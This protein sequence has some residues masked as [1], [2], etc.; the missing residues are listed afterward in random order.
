M[1][2]TNRNTSHKQKYKP[3]FGPDPVHPTAY[4]AAEFDKH[5]WKNFF[6]FC[7]VRNPYE[8]IVSDFMFS[9][10]QKKATVSFREFLERLADSSRP[11][12]E[13]VIPQNPYNWSMYAINDSISVDFIGKYE[14]LEKDFE[15]VCSKLGVPFQNSSLPTI[16]RIRS[17]GRSY[18]DWYSG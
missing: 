2:F 15:F 5:A 13:N 8:R 3:V 9:T 7:F 16:K 6:K 4:Q 1:P 12:P 18:R 11:D 14:S 17:K 10:Q